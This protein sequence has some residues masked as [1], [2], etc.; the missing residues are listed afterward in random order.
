MALACRKK[1]RVLLKIR[2]VYVIRN[3]TMNGLAVFKNYSEV[4]R[5]WISGISLIKFG[6]PQIIIQPTSV[7]DCRRYFKTIILNLIKKLLLL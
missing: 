1:N 5:L 3:L 2:E 4:S 7:L 6:R